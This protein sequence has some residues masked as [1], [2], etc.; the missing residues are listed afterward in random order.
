MATK[1]PK[2][3]DFTA[4]LAKNTVKT[5]MLRRYGHFIERKKGSETGALSILLRE[6]T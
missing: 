2:M 3:A 4:I 1:M 5:P 6:L